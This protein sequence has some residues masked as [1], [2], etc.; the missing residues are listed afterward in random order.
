[1]QKI[2]SYNEYIN[3]P[4]T[5]S[6][7]IKAM[8]KLGVKKIELEKISQRAGY[9]YLP[10]T[11]AYYLTNFFV[12]LW[13]TIIFLLISFMVGLVFVRP[14]PIGRLLHDN[15]FL[16]ISAITFLLL[17]WLNIRYH[18]HLDSYIDTYVTRGEQ[19]Y[20]FYSLL[21]EEFPDY[22]EKIIKII[23]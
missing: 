3:Y 18:Y 20:Y 17:T 13:S 19:E 5:I 15:V 22:L 1:M 2:L 21:A 16:C 8:L 7:L 14:A 11:K 6:Q 9:I 23:D 12:Q 4:L 10:G